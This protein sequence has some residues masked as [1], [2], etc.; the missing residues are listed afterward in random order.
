MS[1]LSI[2]AVL[3][4]LPLASHAA[5]TNFRPGLWHM[6][7]SSGLLALAGQI[8]PQQMQGLSDLARQYGLA[9]PKISNGEAESEVCLTAD[10]AAQAIP[11]SFYNSQ[12]GCEARNAVRNGDRFST[13]IVCSG[14]DI[15]GQ[16]RAEATLTSQESFTGVTTFRGAVNG[17]PVDDRADTSGRWI[18]AACPAATAPQA[19]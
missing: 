5:E 16:G 19:R 13:D 14:A 12:S 17:V 9:M 18:A 3:L 10:M 2:L 1:R 7:T 6:R 11:P 8:P 15:Q 4:A